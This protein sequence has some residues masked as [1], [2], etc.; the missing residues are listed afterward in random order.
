MQVSLIITVRSLALAWDNWHPSRRKAQSL[1]KPQ[2][3]GGKQ[4][5]LSTQPAAVPHLHPQQA[6]GPCLSH[7]PSRLVPTHTKA[8]GTCARGSRDS[9]DADSPGNTML[10]PCKGLDPSV[11]E[12]AGFPGG[13]ADAKV[14]PEASIPVMEPCSALQR[15][16]LRAG[17]LIRSGA[18]ARS[19]PTAGT[20]Q[21]RQHCGDRMAEV[22]VAV[23]TDSGW[24]TGVMAH[25][26]G[27]VLT[28]AHAVRQDS[29][30]EQQPVTANGQQ[31]PRLSRRRAS[32]VHSFRL[33]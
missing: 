27:I 14:G 24:A 19:S 5:S 12:P 8:V 18:V 26:C 28:V 15:A 33:L 31:T 32:A 7:T 29:C 22:I 2:A 11:R 16:D 20:Q 30:S 21:A 3:A 1:L 25:P 13:T 10:R 6:V 4:S 23:T 17:C 9:P